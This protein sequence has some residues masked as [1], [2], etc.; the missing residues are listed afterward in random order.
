M[1][2]KVLGPSPVL[3][4]AVPEGK[5]IRLTWNNYGTN[6]IS[7][8]NIYRR[9][10]PSTFKPDSCTS[11][12]PASTGFIKIGFIAGSATVSFIDT[13]NGQGL[14]FGKE[15]SYRIVAVYPNG[16]ESIVSNEISSSLVSGVPVIT[17]VS[18]RNTSVT[19]GS[20]LLSWKKPDRLDTI[21][22]TGP[23]EYLI[24][25]AAGITGTD[26]QQIRSIQTATLNETQIIDT[27]INTQSR[28]L[29][30]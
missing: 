28:G 5:F 12:I 7:G 27:L 18:V 21:P 19:N 3:V 14:Q 4:N 1:K 9:E 16:A 25:R 11:G 22:A 26:Y 13:D 8:F 2:I 17:H 24:Y 6:V 23:Y 29:Y 30:I 15:Y 10:G 20:I